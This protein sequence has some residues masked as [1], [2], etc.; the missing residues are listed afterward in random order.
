MVDDLSIL[1]NLSLSEDEKSLIKTEISEGRIITIPE[2]DITIQQWKGTG[3]ILLDP[4][5]GIGAYKISGNLNG[6]EHPLAATAMATLAIY[7]EYITGTFFIKCYYDIDCSWNH[8]SRPY[9]RRPS[10][11]GCRTYCSLLYDVFIYGLYDKW[12]R[13]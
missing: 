1:D 10:Y 4:E 2:E 5:T 8:R 7:A 12:R 9:L 13:G 6:G 3:Y 11:T